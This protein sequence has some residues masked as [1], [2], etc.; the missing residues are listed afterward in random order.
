MKISGF[1][2]GNNITNLIKYLGF[3][4]TNLE[5]IEAKLLWVVRLRWLAL[6]LFTVSI[7]PNYSLGFLNRATMPIYIG[8]ISM[9][10]VLNLI[11]SLKL[12]SPQAKVPSMTLNIHLGIDVLVLTLLL[13]FVKG[14]NN[15]LFYLYLLNS[16]IAG[17]LIGYKRESYSLLLLIHS[18]V[19]FI[20]VHFL[21]NNGSIIDKITVFQ[22]IFFHILVLTFWLVMSTLGKYIKNQNQLRY[23]KLMNQ[24]KQDRLRAL[25]ALSAGFSHEFAS[26]LNTLQIRLDR[27]QREIKS[28]N[29]NLYEALAAVEAC[30]LVIHQM[31]SSQLDSRACKS[32]IVKMD[33]FLNDIIDSW[34]EENYKAKIIRRIDCNDSLKLAT[35]NF[36]QVIFNLLD[37]AA[38]S[39]AS[40]VI[41]F[42]F[43]KLKN[44][45]YVLEVEDDG[46]GFSKEILERIGEP[47]VTTKK[48]GTGLGMYLT[49]LLAQSLGGNLE[50][51]N[52]QSKGCVVKIKWPIFMEEL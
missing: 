1:F 26:P 16:S 12:I 49:Q 9:L 44:S 18:C 10:F 34:S 50:I 47:F 52:L 14:Y 20:Q 31:N 39:E 43:Y 23:K 40:S 35:L 17:A 48:N 8:I 2:L 32:K 33:E 24:E 21:S 29:D 3:Q 22:F 19:L 37:N 51:A 11:S 4:V 46:A 13:Y 38:Q 15:P 7:V 5:Q 27:L 25:G 36:S 28:H 42:R 30:K 41:K 45:Y 6:S